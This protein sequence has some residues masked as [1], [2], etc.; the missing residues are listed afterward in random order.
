[1][2]C[3]SMLSEV[4]MQLAT[5][6][7][8]IMLLVQAAPIAVPVQPDAAPALKGGAPHDAVPALAHIVQ[9]IAVDE[10][11]KARGSIMRRATLQDRSSIW[12]LWNCDGRSLHE[13]QHGPKLGRQLPRKL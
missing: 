11:G 7:G 9:L 6:P 4:A 3:N 13:Q 2:G 5:Q 12:L 8:L 10:A 1:M